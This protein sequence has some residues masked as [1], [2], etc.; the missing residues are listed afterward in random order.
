MIFMLGLII[1]ISIISVVCIAE[2]IAI[3]LMLYKKKKDD[4]GHFIDLKFCEIENSIVKI[5]EEI[6]DI[7][8]SL[9]VLSNRKK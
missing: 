2:A 9:T 3:V 8:S 1:W 5:K 7:N 6:E 4:N